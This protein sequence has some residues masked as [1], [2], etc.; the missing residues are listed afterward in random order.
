M[1]VLY[2]VAYIMLQFF[3]K[4]K[5][6]INSFHSRLESPEINI[7]VFSSYQIFY[8]FFPFEETSVPPTL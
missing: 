6:F 1:E 4:S 8:Y 7:D 5:A 3:F 2:F